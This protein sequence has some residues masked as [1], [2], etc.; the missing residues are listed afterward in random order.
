MQVPET[1]RAAY[2]SQTNDKLKGDYKK[3][4]DALKV[5]KLATY[6]QISDYQN[7]REPNV[8]SR[9]LAEM[10]RLEL[11]YKPGSKGTT[12]RNRQAFHYAL[13]GTNPE[14]GLLPERFPSGSSAADIACSLIAKAENTKKAVQKALG[15]SNQASLF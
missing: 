13:I 8:I 10:E 5:L 6:E 2:D 11:I 9:R 1:S 3:I 4:I 15:V 12:K 14:I 7:C